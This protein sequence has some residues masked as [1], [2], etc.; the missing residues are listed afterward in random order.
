MRNYIMIN[1]LGCINM[2]FQMSVECV[3][4]QALARKQLPAAYYL[5]TGMSGLRLDA[6]QKN[7]YIYTPI[8]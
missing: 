1:A 7:S 6:I 5:K 2:K 3:L 4:N 8:R